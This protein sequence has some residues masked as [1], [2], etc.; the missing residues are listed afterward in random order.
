[1]TTT[2]GVKR[3]LEPV[4]ALVDR[5]MNRRRFIQLS[6]SA[7]AGLAVAGCT[8]PREPGDGPGPR[9]ITTLGDQALPDTGIILPHEHIFLDLRPPSHP[10]LGQAQIENVVEVMQ[11]LLE[12][13][14]AAGVAVLVD[15]APVGMGR[16]AD[17]IVAVSRAA[18]LPVLLPTGLYCD[19]FMPEWARA[20]SEEDVRDWMVGELIGGIEE[21]RVEASWIKLCA[22]DGGLTEQEQKALRA[23][24]GAG[25][26]T[27][28]T[29]GCHIESGVVARHALDIVER[30]GYSAER[31]VWIHADHE[32]DGAF[33][34]ELARRGAWVEFDAIGHARGDTWHIDRIR[35]MLDAGLGG[36]VLLSMDSGWYDP[37]LSECRAGC[38]EGYTY[39]SETFL[40]K[41][42][43][44]GVDE[45]TVGTLTR[46]NPFHAF[47]RPG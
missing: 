47:A 16:R 30:S 4:D 39:L 14:R 20:A 6:A 41:L 40:P 22:S 8:V 10:E 19:R 9:L 12:Q 25:V 17:I 34:E 15:A 35:Q 13:A 31:F 38:I 45:A 29:V 5:Y 46:D 42:R 44:A 43:R 24:A 2:T 21:T 18:R 36:R 1:V 7:V 33:H 27:D 3:W 32:A 37:A 26:A 28:A 11:P 23:A